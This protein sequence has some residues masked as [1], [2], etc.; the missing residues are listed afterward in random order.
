MARNRQPSTEQPIHT[1][2]PAFFLELP[3][4]VTSSQAKRLRAHLEAARQL[5][6]A[7]LSEG[8][9]RL[10]HMRADPGGPAARAIPR[11]Q[12]LDRQ[13]AFAALR[14]QYGISLVRAA[15]GGQNLEL[16][17]GPATTWMPCWPRRWPRVPIAR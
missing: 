6:N 5:Y 17:A 4:Q 3:L 1:H 2:K 8:Q 11:S 15:R 16:R 9:Q 12:K 14:A 13:R 7:L 10:R